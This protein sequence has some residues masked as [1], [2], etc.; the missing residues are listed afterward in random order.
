MVKIEVEVDTLAQFDEALALNP[1]IIL[2]DNFSSENLRKAVE[3]RD[4]SGASVLLETSGRVTE[5][6]VRTLAETGVDLISV[7]ALTHSVKVLDLGL[8]SDD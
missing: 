7:G 1:D 5:E 2:L 6:T 4:R 8:D 3:L